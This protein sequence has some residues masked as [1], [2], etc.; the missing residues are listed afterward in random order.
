MSGRVLFI[1][2]GPPH[3]FAAVLHDHIVPWLCEQFPDVV[4]LELRI[5][6]AEGIG[7]SGIV[8]RLEAAGFQSLETV[9]GFYPGFGR[10]E[11]RLTAPA[12][13]KSALDEAERTLRSL[14]SDY[15]I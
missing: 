1:V 6:T 8:E 5:L 14:L 15:L 2:P 4:P 7:E 12:D 3:E 9:I 13:K 10:V 11:I